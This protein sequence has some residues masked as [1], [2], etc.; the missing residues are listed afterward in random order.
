MGISIILT[1]IFSLK[2]YN[3][4]IATSITPF[5]TILLGFSFIFGGS[6]KTAFDSLIFVFSTHPFDAGD[7]VVIDGYEGSYC[8]QEI[9][10]YTTTLRTS[11]RIL[12]IP[13]GFVN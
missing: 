6:A 11:G 10:L 3:L 8:I 9:T 13:N 12:Y 7:R 2:I 4:D 1:V 5:L